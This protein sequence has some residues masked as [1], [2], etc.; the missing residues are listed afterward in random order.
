MISE[1]PYCDGRRRGGALQLAGNVSDITTLAAAKLVMTLTSLK[2]HNSC[3]DMSNLQRGSGQEA[4][5][6]ERPS[7]DLSM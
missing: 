6:E 7:G 2:L 4:T 1:E 3:G 5:R